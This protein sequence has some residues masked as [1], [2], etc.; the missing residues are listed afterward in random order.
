[1]NLI[2]LVQIRA[3]IPPPPLLDQYGNPLLDQY[4]NPVTKKP[5]KKRHVLYNP[6]DYD[7]DEVDD[8]KD[9]LGDS[10]DTIKKHPQ[11]KKHAVAFL[12]AVAAALALSRLKGYEAG[13]AEEEIVPL[14]H[15]KAKREALA[16]ALEIS[17]TTDKTTGKLV[18]SDSDYATD[19]KRAERI[20]KYESAKAFYA[21]LKDAHKGSHIRKSWVVQSDN[22]CD[23]CEE[24]EDEGRINFDDVFDHGQGAPPLH[25]NCQCMLMLH[26]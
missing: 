2:T 26:Y 6:R 18:K 23:E 5:K 9:L 4:G 17:R 12:L 24:A 14:Y 20:A 3:A 22:P 8:L 11:K 25:L 13:D 19:P 1:M 10:F 7:E 21:G 15:K 16:R